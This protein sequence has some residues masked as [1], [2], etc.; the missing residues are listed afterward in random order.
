MVIPNRR[1]YEVRPE[2]RQLSGQVPVNPDRERQM[3]EQE[4]DRERVHVI[5]RQRSVAHEDVEDAADDPPP[6]PPGR[7]SLGPAVAALDLELDRP[8]GERVDIEEDRPIDVEVAQVRRA[9]LGGRTEGRGVRSGISFALR[10][11]TLWA[12]RPSAST[13]RKA[14]SSRSPITA[15]RAASKPERNELIRRQ[16]PAWRGARIPAIGASSRPLSARRK[17]TSMPRNEE[18]LAVAMRHHRVR[19]PRQAPTPPP[20]SASRGRR[21]RPNESPRRNHR[22]PRTLSAGPSGF[23][24]AHRPR[25]RPGARARR[26]RSSVSARSDE[27]RVVVRVI[28]DA[29]ASSPSVSSGGGSK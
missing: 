29:P 21:R 14:A 27:Q 13:S 23:R 16:R 9:K 1:E 8:E 18:V 7:Q 5:A 22:W 19:A 11:P 15:W 3:Q 24:S 28:G 20:G 4:G 2:H 25:R 6:Q 17:R 12:T 10:Y 26:G